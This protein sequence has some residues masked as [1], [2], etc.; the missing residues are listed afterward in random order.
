MQ[1]GV[2][3]RDLMVIRLFFQINFS[4]G[5]WWWIV[6]H[7]IQVVRTYEYEASR[8]KRNTPART[9]LCSWSLVLNSGTLTSFLLAEDQIF[10]EIPF[11]PE[12]HR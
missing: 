8:L 7:H 9:R 11:C 1:L 12:M 6:L 5:D 10:F 4:S 3:P 2:H